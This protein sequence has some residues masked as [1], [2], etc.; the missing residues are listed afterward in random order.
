ML[1]R[2]AMLTQKDHLDAQ[3]HDVQAKAEKEAKDHKV[4]RERET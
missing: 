4:E 3:I 2:T 1:D